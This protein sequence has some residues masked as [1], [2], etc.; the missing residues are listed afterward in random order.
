M[1]SLCYPYSSMLVV[2]VKGKLLPFVFCRIDYLFTVQVE[3]DVRWYVTTATLSL[4][5]S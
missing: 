5:N 2:V 4:L 1:S 3:I